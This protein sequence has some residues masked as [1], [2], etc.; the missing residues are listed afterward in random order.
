MENLLNP[1]KISNLMS[2]IQSFSRGRYKNK[3][4]QRYR[5]LISLRKIRPAP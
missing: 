1:L 5:S 2:K 4:N 3:E